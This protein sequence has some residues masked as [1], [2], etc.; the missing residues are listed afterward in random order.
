MADGMESLKLTVNED[1]AKKLYKQKERAELDQ[2]KYC[3]AFLESLKLRRMI[4]RHVI[5][6]PGF[7]IIVRIVP[8]VLKNVQT[9]GTIIWK[10]YPDDRKRPGRFKIYTIAL[11]VRIELNS[12]Q[13]IEV[14]S[15]VRVVC[16]RLG[17]VST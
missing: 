4:S 12:I 14:V 3:K 11:I 5:I 13:A 2:C 1:F 16:D 9:I 17:S 8:V 7:H 15:V 10:R 6:K